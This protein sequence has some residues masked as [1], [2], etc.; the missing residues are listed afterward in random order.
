[1]DKGT[2][3]HFSREDIKMAN[4]YMKKWP[5]SLKMQI[6]ATVRYHLTP[7]IKKNRDKQVLAMIG[8][9]ESLGYSAQVCKLMQLHEKR[10]EGS[11]KN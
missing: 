6:K 1:M 5:T 2:K 8:K 10:Y 9:R 3:R 7:A 4:K 11:S